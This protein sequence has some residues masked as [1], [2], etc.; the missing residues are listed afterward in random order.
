MI[1]PVA[2]R[3]GERANC[4]KAVSSAIFTGYIFYT[5]KNRGGKLE[6]VMIVVLETNNKTDV[7]YHQAPRGEIEM[8]TTNKQIVFNLIRGASRRQVRR[9]NINARR[10]FG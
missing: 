9:D 7:P 1:Y 10:S 5:E 4:P 6:N 8:D 2:R 3:T